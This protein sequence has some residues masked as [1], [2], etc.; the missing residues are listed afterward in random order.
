LLFSL[1]AKSVS[2]TFFVMALATHRRPA[3]AGVIILNVLFSIG[4]LRANGE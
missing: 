3:A 4:S 1:P 2:A